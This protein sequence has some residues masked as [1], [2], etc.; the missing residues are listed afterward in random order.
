MEKI[1]LL[2]LN[3]N[4]FNSYLKKFFKANVAIKEGKIFYIDK[5]C[6]ME[7]SFK[8]TVDAKGNYLIPGF[9]DIH[10]HIES[11]MLTPLAM[12]QRLGECGV[13]TIVSEP[14][15]MANVSGVDGVLAMI[16]A[17]EKAP[18]DI[19]YGIP[20]SVPSTN[21][22][23]EG[24]GGVINCEDMIALKENDS[25][26]CVGEVMNYRE[27]IK[28]NN[29]EITKFINYL[30]KTDPRFPIEGHCPNLIDLDLAKFLFLGINADH[31][32]HDMTSFSQ[33]IE[34]GMFMQVQ[35]KMLKKEF[36][37]YLMQNNLYEHFCFATDDVM[38]DDLHNKGHLNTLVKKAVSLG[39][40]AEDA[41]YCTSFTP[42]R[43][44]QLFD[45]GSIAPG[46]LADFILLDNLIEF[47]PLEVYK[48]GVR[49]DNLKIDLENSF[50]KEYYNTVKL[51]K[52][53]KED[54]I[55]RADKSLDKVTVRVINVNPTTTRTTMTQAVLDV[56]DGIVQWENTAYKL[57]VVFNRYG[58]GEMGIGF[59]T[60]A[61][62]K[63]GAV[64]TTYA[65]DCHNLLVCGDNI[66]DI[67]LA[68]NTII[69]TQGGY[70]ATKDNKVIGQIVLSVGGILSDKSVSETA[71][72]A[73]GL[74][75]A[76]INLGYEHY[77]PIMSFGTLTLP[78]S[79]EFKITDKGLISVSKGEIMPLF[80][81]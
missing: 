40:R 18:I 58:S 57:A 32:E 80:I 36:I 24:T 35:E 70:V 77:S 76:M 1:D 6:K 33:R 47:T 37:D 49:I 69:D 50:A 2:V 75:K 72:Q 4:V 59:I 78:V 31:T 30:K 65:H 19:F 54:F 16:K 64:G 39:M 23:L 27:V 46:K 73:Q 66:D 41:I 11:S 55:I 8:E 20:S 7:F 15:E 43:R 29:L 25:V 9:I 3:A 51:S 14:H 63:T 68:T 44:M 48:N 74:R 28:E 26:I 10:M 81:D 56:K 5:S 60:G 21:P 38:V 53:T 67:L 79:P 45:R 42:A 62:H 12:A 17:G 52:K 71:K 34:N 22:D 61:I 13:T